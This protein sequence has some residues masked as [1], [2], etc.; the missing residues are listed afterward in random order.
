ALD[1]YDN[2]RAVAGNDVAFPHFLL[3]G[4]AGVGKSLL[5]SVLAPE[6]CTKFHEEL[7]QNISSPGHLH[8]LLMLAEAGDVIFVDEIHEL[9][10]TCQVTLYRSLEERRLFLGRDRKSITLPPHTFV[11]AT[12]DEWQLAKPLRD[13]FRVVLRLTHYSDQE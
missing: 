5:A 12:T 7:A 11:G 8:G 3:V 2:D 13:R 10:S 4:P 9:S 6:L 1:A